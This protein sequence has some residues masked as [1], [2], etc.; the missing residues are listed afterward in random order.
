MTSLRW[1][2]FRLPMRRRFEAAHGALADRDGVLIEIADSDGRRGVGEASPI[3]SLGTG[4][5]QDVLALLRRHGAALSATGGAPDAPG[6]LDGLDTRAP[7]VA[8]LRCALDV[9]WL[10]LQGQRTGR[11]IADLIAPPGVPVASEVR[12]NAV[13]GEGSAEETAEFGREAVTLG[14][15]VLKTKV[16]GRPLDEDVR[17]ITALR[18]ACPD[19]AIRLDA[20]GAWDEATAMQAV[21][22]LLPLSIELI[23]Q[24][25][26]AAEVDALA[27]VRAAATG[28]MWIAADEA[29]T[30]A[31][32]L[33]RVLALQAADLVVLKPMFLGGLRAAV[34]VARRAAEYGIGAFAT[35]TFDSSIG[36]AAALHLAGALGG[37][38]A[39]GLG[40]GEHLAAD[41]LTETLMPTRG[42]LA[43][44]D[45]AGLGI[46]PEDAA[47][48]RVA[49]GDW[50]AP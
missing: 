4:T 11:R 42:L 26:P 49:Q 46:A 37:G 14:Y 34:E 12:V 3:A 35:T 28:A 50:V 6:A 47:W 24:P 7:G 10:D 40:T 43:L 41:L 2:A 8:A 13:I 39:H 23:E 33:E 38:L 45:R 30:H 18:E 25:V 22:G 17:R 48:H 36:T 5:V 16:G 32:T 19:V 20:N 29:V 27:R 9:A 44:P 15:R 1:R 31:A 21:R